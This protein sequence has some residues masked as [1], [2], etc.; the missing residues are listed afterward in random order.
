MSV[1]AHSSCRV[2]FVP[3]PNLRLTLL[4]SDL[5]PNMR[6]THCQ[7]H[8]IFGILREN[9]PMLIV[10]ILHERMDMIKQLENRLK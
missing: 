2:G 8:Y 7:H 6:V 1:I 10:A 5:Y 4:M 9:S 3:Q